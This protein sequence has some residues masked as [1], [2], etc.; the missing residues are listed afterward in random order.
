MCFDARYE[1]GRLF[2][3]DMH[4]FNLAMLADRIGKKAIEAVAN[5][6]VDAV[7][8]GYHDGFS[9]LIYNR[10]CHALLLLRSSET[11]SGSN[12]VG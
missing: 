9:E 6:A 4:P 12:V 10:L 7:D 3:F 1:C 2:I 5:N 8:A 11:R